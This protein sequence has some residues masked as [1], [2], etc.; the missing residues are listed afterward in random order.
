MKIAEKIAA[1]QK[2]ALHQNIEHSNGV[3]NIKKNAV[4]ISEQEFV[5]FYNTTMKNLNNGELEY[6]YVDPDMDMV[7]VQYKFDRIET[8][9][10]FKSTIETAK[11]GCFT[12]I[13]KKVNSYVMIGQHQHA[14]VRPANFEYSEVKFKTKDGAETRAFDDVLKHK[15]LRMLADVVTDEVFRYTNNVG[16]VA[17]I[18]N[19][20]RKPMV[21]ASRDAA[22]SEGKLF[23]L[24]WEQDDLALDMTNVGYLN[25][26]RA[27][28]LS[29]FTAML[30]NRQSKNFY[31]TRYY[32]TLNDL[33]WTSALTVVSAG[34]MM[35]AR[36]VHCKIEKI[37]IQVTVNK[38]LDLSQSYSK[39][40]TDV[41]VMGLRY[42]LGSNNVQSELVSKVKEQLQHFIEKSLESNIQDYLR[43]QFSHY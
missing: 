14:V 11:R 27:A 10:L 21:I 31:R 28:E 42:D 15:Y 43:Q 18:K 5:I 22:N 7:Y 38:S 20:I 36:N 16:M 3:L 32:F 12:V 4:K 34:N 6:M 30:V 1:L 37:K 9:G 25:A 35:T 8:T 29:I 39:F 13:L 33:E 19:E 40:N 2:I 17:Q 24:R 41:H 23:D 26:E